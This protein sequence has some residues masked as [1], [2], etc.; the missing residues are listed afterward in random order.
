MVCGRNEDVEINVWRHNVVQ[1]KDQKIK[2]NNESDRNIRERSY[3][4]LVR[5]CIEKGRS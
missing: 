1:N 2:S 5:A 4:K 3:V